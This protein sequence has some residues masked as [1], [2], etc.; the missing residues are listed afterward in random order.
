MKHVKLFEEFL[1]EDE[2]GK[3]ITYDDG[4]YKIAISDDI[5]PTRISLWENNKNIGNL[6]TGGILK[7]DD[8]KLIKISSIEIDKKHRGNGLSKLMY[9]TLLKHILYDGI[10]SYLPDRINKK[11]IPSIY[12]SLGGHIKDDYAI[13]LK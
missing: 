8:L 4:N 9:K 10:V 1:Y 6:Y 7:L 2:Y 5:N 12:K 3:A 13:I 11:Q